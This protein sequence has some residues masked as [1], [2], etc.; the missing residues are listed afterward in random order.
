MNSDISMKNIFHSCEGQ[1]IQPTDEKELR[2]TINRAVDYR[3]D[4]TIQLKTGEQVTGYVFDRDEN[5]SHPYV[6]IFLPNYREPQIVLYQQIAGVMFSGEDMAF[7]RSWE[8][9]A[10][11]WKKPESRS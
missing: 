9:W 10:Q 5:A 8:N 7:G 11:K 6:K 3:G 2:E 1:H 4:V